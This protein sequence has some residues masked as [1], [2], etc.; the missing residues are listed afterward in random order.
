MRDLKYLDALAVA[1]AGFIWVRLSLGLFGMDLYEIYWWF[2]A[3]M[4]MALS[5][6]TSILLR[7]TR[8]LVSVVGAAD[9]ELTN[10]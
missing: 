4:G 3:G 8:L 9:D 10:G 6:V 2:G 7:Q 1:T 5:N